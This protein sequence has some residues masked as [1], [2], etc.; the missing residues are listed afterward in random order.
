MVRQIQKERKTATLT[1]QR[2]RKNLIIRVEASKAAFERLASLG[3]RPGRKALA[4]VSGI[5]NSGYSFR[6]V[7]RKVIQIQRA[8]RAYQERK[9]ARES[10]N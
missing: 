10:R 7:R 5:M 1:L 9:R 8:W 4:N 2:Y 3:S 6:A